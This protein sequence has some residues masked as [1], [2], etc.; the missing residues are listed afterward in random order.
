MQLGVGLFVAPG[1]AR[2]DRESAGGGVL[3]NK[4][5]RHAASDRYRRGHAVLPMR[6]VLDDDRHGGREGQTDRTFTARE[7]AG[8]TR[9]VRARTRGGGEARRRGGGAR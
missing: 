5:H 9:A 2:V 7:V 3:D 8:A 6:V 1:L 4:W